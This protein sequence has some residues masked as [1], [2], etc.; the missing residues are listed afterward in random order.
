RVVAAKTA[1]SQRAQQILQRLEAEEIDRFVCDLKTRF[2]GALLWLPDLPERRCLRRWRHLRRLL[3]ID[4]ALARKA[5][6]QLLDQVAYLF[7]VHCAGIL[8]HLAQLFAHRIFGK[9]VAFLE[10][11][12]NRFAQR[13]HRALVF[14]LGKA[15]VLRLKTALQKEVTQPLYE[16]V[17]VHRVGRLSRIFSVFDHLHC[18]PS[19][20]SCNLGAADGSAIRGVPAFAEVSPRRSLALRSGQFSGAPISL[21]GSFRRPQPQPPR[22]CGSSRRACPCG[23]AG[24]GLSRVAGSADWWWQFRGSSTRLPL[25]TTELPAGSSHWGNAC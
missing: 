20:L 7:V 2:G 23:S 3:G 15:V 5:I 25:Q 9:Q 1:P 18:V 12:Q 17:K 19:M 22:L 10:G 4:V 21:R 11:P 6:H 16:F 8:Q 13:F 14:K 24:P